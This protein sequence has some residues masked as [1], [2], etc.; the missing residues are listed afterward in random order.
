M[1]E[2]EPTLLLKDS[3]SD[4]DDDD[5]KKK[6]R[7]EIIRKIAGYILQYHGLTEA[8]TA[9]ELATNSTFPTALKAHDGS[10]GGLHRRIKVEKSLVPPCECAACCFPPTR[11]SAHPPIR[12]STRTA[13]HGAH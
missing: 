3:D 4:S 10:Y 11:P 6:R 7:K 2:R 8:Y 13:I 5:K 1:L 12:P 9:R